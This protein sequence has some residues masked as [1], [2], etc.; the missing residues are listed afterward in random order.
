[1]P[2]RDKEKARAYMREYMNKRRAKKRLI[3]SIQEKAKSIT[4]EWRQMFEII[5]EMAFTVNRSDLTDS[6]KIARIKSITIPKELMPYFRDL[7]KEAR[8]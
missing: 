4:L 5:R 1:M 2:I 8:M 7:P 3:K 6:E